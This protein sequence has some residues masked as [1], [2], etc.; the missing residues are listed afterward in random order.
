LGITPISRTINLLSTVDFSN[1]FN[2]VVGL[3]KVLLL[4]ERPRTYILH[5]PLFYLGGGCRH[6]TTFYKG[7]VGSDVIGFTPKQP[8]FFMQIYAENQGVKAN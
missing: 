1:C 8:L 5:F 7:I 4:I 3:I 2:G 6:R